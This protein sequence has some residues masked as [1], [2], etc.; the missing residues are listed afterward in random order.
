VNSPI[1]ES[2]PDAGGVIQLEHVRCAVCGADDTRF[3]HHKFGLDVVQCSRCGLVYANPR[4]PKPALMTRYSDT[5][6]WDEYLPDQ[7]VGR[8]G[9]VDLDLVWKK[10]EPLLRLFETYHPPPGDLLEIGAAA[11]LFMKSAERAGWQVKGIEPMAPAV[12]FARDRLGLDV[13]HGTLEEAGLAPASFDAVVMFDTI[14]H[15]PNPVDV[16]ASAHRLP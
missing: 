16:L 3:R 5:Y 7:G 12:A 1:T 2:K 6:F 13:I 4:L 9:N 15:V 10:H 14:E 8:D 11:G